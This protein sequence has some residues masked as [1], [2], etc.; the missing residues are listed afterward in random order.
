MFLIEFDILFVKPNSS[1]LLS[2]DSG[3]ILASIFSSIK[4]ANFPGSDIELYLP[5]NSLNF[6]LK[7]V[8]SV[9]ASSK[10]ELAFPQRR[11]TVISSLIKLQLFAIFSAVS[12]L[13]PVNIHIFIFAK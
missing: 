7:S 3:N 5:L 9:I 2:S 1:V 12:I 4:M 11:N 10:P 8:I 6:K 13:S